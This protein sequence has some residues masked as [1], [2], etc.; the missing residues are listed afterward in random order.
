MTLQTTPCKSPGGDG[1]LDASQGTHISA[2]HV[3]RMTGQAH[4]NQGSL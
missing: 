3:T 4:P 1:Q 2:K